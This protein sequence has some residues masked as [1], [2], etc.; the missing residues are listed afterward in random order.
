MVS[1]VAG[2]RGRE[3]HA[4]DLEHLFRRSCVLRRRDALSPSRSDH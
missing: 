3:E 2:G 1:S 4:D